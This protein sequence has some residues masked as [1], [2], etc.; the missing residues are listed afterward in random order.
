MP[1][2]PVNRAGD[3]SGGRRGRPLHPVRGTFPVS[4]PDGT[5]PETSARPHREA[6]SARGRAQITAGASLPRGPSS[7]GQTSDPDPLKRPRS[8]LPDISR[9]R[10]RPIES[11]MPREQRRDHT[12][13]SIGNPQG[14]RRHARRGSAPRSTI[15]SI[16]RALCLIAK[17][18]S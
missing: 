4:Q 2:V 11:Q 6:E 14:K 10:P 3:R 18:R 1:G 15:G 8:L 16:R 7:R 13:E 5:S 12:S 17:D 9:S